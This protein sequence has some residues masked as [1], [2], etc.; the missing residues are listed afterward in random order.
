[1]WEQL[2]WFRSVARYVRCLVEVEGRNPST[3]LLAEVRQMEDRLGLTPAALMR[4]HWEVVEAEPEDEAEDL[5][6]PRL[7]LVNPLAVEGA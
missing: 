3:R 4:L 7:R 1:M 5:D 2:A 6:V